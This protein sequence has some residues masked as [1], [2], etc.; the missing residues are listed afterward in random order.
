MPLSDR[1]FDKYNLHK[2]IIK[3]LYLGVLLNIVIPGAMLFVCFYLYKNNYYINAVF[4]DENANMLF[5]VIAILAIVNTGI[6]LWIRQKLFTTSMVVNEEKFEEELTLSLFEKIRPVYI[7][8]SVIAVYGVCYYFLTAR[9]EEAA[10]FV[11]LS[12]LVFQVV[13][14]RVGFIQ[15]LI[16]AQLKLLKNRQSKKIN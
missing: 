1:R 13:R 11:I 4:E 7:L 10:F 5:I 9:F 6:A 2:M 15:K 14:P 8:I 12:F 3:P 16:D